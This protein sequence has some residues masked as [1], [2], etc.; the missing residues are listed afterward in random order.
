MENMLR[1]IVETDK[2]SRLDVQKAML[3]REQLTRELAEIKE[4]I[5]SEYKQKAEKRIENARRSA[6]KETAEIK[7]KIRLETDEKSRALSRVYE[8]NREE[9]ENAVFNAV[10]GK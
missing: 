1:E 4:Q 3:R 7:E 9:W 5:D 8:E 10:T 2:A 6:Q